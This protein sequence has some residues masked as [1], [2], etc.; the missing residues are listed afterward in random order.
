MQARG[1]CRGRGAEHHR[2]PAAEQDAHVGAVHLAI[3]VEVAELRARDAPPAEQDADAPVVDGAV[4]VEVTDAVLAGVRGA[5]GIPARGAG[6]DVG[7]VG[8]A[9]AVAVGGDERPQ[10]D[11]ALERGFP[12]LGELDDIGRA[13]VDLP[14]TVNLAVDD[15]DHHLVGA[16]L[17]DGLDALL[18]DRVGLLEN[19]D[20]GEGG[21]GGQGERGQANGSVETSARSVQFLPGTMNEGLEGSRTIH[22]PRPTADGIARS[23]RTDSRPAHGTCPEGTR[24]DGSARPDDGCRSQNPTAF[25]LPSLVMSTVLVQASRPERRLVSVRRKV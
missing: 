25:L 16:F 21:G 20:V 12:F 22:G 5:V 2:S 1:R 11:L 19:L 8:L 3:A 10:L 9:V 13:L 7:R 15:R 18:G 24:S 23:P 4:Q 14:L 6:G 17:D